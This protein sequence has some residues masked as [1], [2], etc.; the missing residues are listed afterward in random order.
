MGTKVQLDRTKNFQ[1]DTAQKKN[2]RTAIQS[3][4]Q[5]SL[6]GRFER[7]QLKDVLFESDSN[8]NY[9]DMNISHCVHLLEMSIKNKTL[10]FKVYNTNISNESI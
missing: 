7:F 6:E 9:S 2:C 8:V 1:C 5:N 3:I 4:F 10:L